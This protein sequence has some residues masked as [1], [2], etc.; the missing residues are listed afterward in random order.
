MLSSMKNE[1]LHNTI[2]PCKQVGMG[3][4]KPLTG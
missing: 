1:L 2:K 3:G 4:I